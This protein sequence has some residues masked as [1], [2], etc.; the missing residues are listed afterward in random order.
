M[1]S[2]FYTLPLDRCQKPDYALV[3]GTKNIPFKGG[4]HMKRTHWP[5]LGAL[6]VVSFLLVG[7]IACDPV[8]RR[9]LS[10]DEKKADLYW[11]FSQYEENYAPLE[12]K[13]ERL[14]FTMEELKAETLERALATTSN[15]AFYLEMFRF[16]AHF[17]DAHNSGSLTLSD[18]PGRGKVAYLGFNAI[19]MGDWL[20]VTELLPTSAGDAHFPVPVG[21]IITRV[22]GL[23]VK[24]YIDQNLVPYR[25]LGRAETNYTFHANRIFNRV[26]LSQPMPEKDTV[27]LSLMQWN[28]E[29]SE[30]TIP[31]VT[32]D[33]RDYLMRQEEA[34]ASQGG[35]T[36]GST[37]I[38]LMALRDSE[39]T[40]LGLVGFN[41]LFQSV[42]AKL[43]SITRGN[44]AFSIF[45]TFEF[46]DST[47]RW[48]AVQAD[49]PQM[50]AKDFVERSRS[51]PAR[52]FYLDEPE[53]YPAYVMRVNDTLVGVIMIYSFSV[54]GDGAADVAN[55]LEA[56]RELGV[57]HVVLDLI[58]NGGGSLTLGMEV[59]QAF[60]D[61][62]I[63]WPS[64]A[65]GLN[66]SWLDDFERMSLDGGSDLS[67]EMYRRVFTQLKDEAALGRRIST[68][69]SADSLA[70]FAIQPNSNL[71][72][73][74][75]FKIVA[76]V[77]EM[78]ASMCDI[79]TGILKDNGI[80][81]VVGTQTMG[82][83]GNVVNHF[84]APNSHLQVR[85]TESLIIRSNG[86]Y[87][88][89]EGVTPD[90]PFA[91]HESAAIKYRMAL[92]KAIDVV[93][94]Q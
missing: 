12:Y 31:W 57:K 60:T 38:D 3:L 66:E 11:L 15:E 87:I 74:E 75:P 26:N 55:T 43:D 8:P 46:V 85:Q 29:E 24:E 56:F 53:V 69:I 4:N 76:L 65:Y 42:S 5:R 90:V 48:S 18:L 9:V 68:P 50:S 77:N 72:G 91:V 14:G 62:A 58:N 20:L 16:I 70:P 6:A 19:R 61:K 51:L 17:A 47:E 73:E 33:L 86:E 93:L 94:E 63:Q 71:Q 59:A 49:A 25:N 7:T 40:D 64:I 23:T 2:F 28:G 36:I 79:F 13:E 78:C 54:G 37:A 22:D 35:S 39:T 52:A 1:K 88:E 82:A 27:T 21:S 44:K 67:T 10:E 34:Q 30:V 89:N 83:G 45:N 92:N 32:R 80:A 41:G 84:H 81:T